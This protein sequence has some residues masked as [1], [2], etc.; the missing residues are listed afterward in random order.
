MPFQ[1]GDAIKGDAAPE[2]YRTEGGN[3]RW[4]PDAETLHSLGYTWAQVEILPQTEVNQIPLGSPIPSVIQAP[5]YPDGTLLM[6]ISRPEV[7]V[8]EGGRRRWIPDAPTFDCYGYR[9]ADIKQIQDAVLN[10]IPMGSALELCRR[11]ST[12]NVFAPLSV[13]HLMWTAASLLTDTGLVRATTRT[14]SVVL[15]AGFT[16]GAQIVMSDANEEVIGATRSPDP[17]T[18]FATFGV[19][20]RLTG[21]SDRTDTWTDTIDADVARRTDRLTIVHT[22]TPRILLGDRIDEAIRSARKINELITE[23]KSLAGEANAA[24]G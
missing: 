10:A 22:W 13:G 11:I 7:Y 3:R 2:V 19:D 9:W 6:G 1:E 21:R 15:F 5:P 23:V 4:I 8:V 17:S 16:G 12:G 20:G 24:L 18:N 14:Q